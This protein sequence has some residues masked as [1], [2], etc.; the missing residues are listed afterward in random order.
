ML[1]VFGRRSNE[2]SSFAVSENLHY[3]QPAD[4]VRM[5][6]YFNRAAVVRQ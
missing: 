3:D 4:V 5:V 2:V 6:D 1:R